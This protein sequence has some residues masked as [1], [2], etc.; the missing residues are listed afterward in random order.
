M[1]RTF[2]R[3]IRRFSLVISIRKPLTPCIPIR[4]FNSFH[5][6]STFVSAYH[7]ISNSEIRDFLAR[8]G[9]E[10]KETSNGFTARYCPLCPKPHYEERTNL[11]T[12]GFKANSGV[13]HCFRCGV[14]GSWYDFKNLVTGSNLHI[15]AIQ[16]Q[17]T[18]LPSVEEHLTKIHNLTEQKYPTILK[19]L[20]EVRGLTTETLVKYNVGVGM[21][22]F[23]DTETE[24]SID[25]PCVFFPMYLAKNNENLLTRVKIRA[26]YKENK[27][28]MKMH[29]SGGG[30]GFFG[31]NIVPSGIKTIVITEGEYDAL[32]VHQ[33]TGLYAVSLPNGASHLPIQLLPWL[34]QF[35]RIY[36]WLDDDLAGREAAAKF[37]KKLG[38]KRTF[39][40]KT[41]DF[42][43]HGPKDANEALL[44]CSSE[45]MKKF[46][47]LAK[48]IAEENITT[49]R[50]LRE[51]VYNK[52]TKHQEESGIM[53]TSFNWY[54]Q[55][56]KGFRKGELTILTGGTGSGKTTLLSQLSLDFCSQGIPTLWGSFEIK[57]EILLKKLLIQYAKMD[58]TRKPE[59]FNEF[60]DKFQDLPLYLLKFFG[61][62]DIDKILD[63]MDFATYAYDI[64]HIIVDNLQFMLSGQALGMNKFD[65]Q[66]QVISKFRNFATDKNVH[67]T[68]VIHPKKIDDESDLNIASVF[69]SAKATQEADNIFVLQNRHKYRLIDIRKNRFDGEVGR[70][71]LGF[72]K[73]TQSFFE[74]TNQ[75]ITDLRGNPD[76]TVADVLKSRV[77][78]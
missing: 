14:S 55:K 26:I 57:N 20:N 30:F 43:G 70:V 31:L 23:R 64:G 38:L 76:Y 6:P 42:D 27:H 66:D 62:T 34:E 67:L 60:A 17:E 49:F 53:C 9:V 7:E 74:L 69:G 72:D 75:E 11:Y 77:I 33:A 78:I 68:L 65:L 40:V 41:Q 29:P 15:E 18:V 52:M 48:P 39:I 37:A 35:Q 63:T 44:T 24:E 25:L 51:E 10:Y 8:I 54:N 56:T 1:L 46:I 22:Q 58:L 3:Q 45:T 50:E 73:D 21:K 2:S 13:F 5:N 61:S 19:Y 28:Y 32:A 16:S 36:L 47:T 4:G 59:L 12:L 71:G